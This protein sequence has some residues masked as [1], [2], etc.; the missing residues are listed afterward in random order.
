VNLFS[1]GPQVADGG[2]TRGGPAAASVVEQLS[3]IQNLKVGLNFVRT[4]RWCRGR[5]QATACG[6]GWV[7]S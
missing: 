2:V 1:L 4:S 3:P 5:A 7:C 6:A